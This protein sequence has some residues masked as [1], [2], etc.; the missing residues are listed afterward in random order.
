MRYWIAMLGNLTD[1]RE[2]EKLAAVSPV[3]MVARIKAPVF[4][5]HGNE[6]QTV[7]VEQAHAMVA[8]LKKSGNPPETLYLDY[9]G[10]WWP[11]DKK[12][13]EFLR[14]LETFLAA[15]MGK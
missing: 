15:N 12:G 7:P 10:H 6:D 2:R 1:A 3:N 9:V 8:A 13:E 14:R 4:I 5:M 11:T